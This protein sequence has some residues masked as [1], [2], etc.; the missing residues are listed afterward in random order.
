MGFASLNPSY[1]L[2]EIPDFA[3]CIRATRCGRCGS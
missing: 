3:S 2:H 1:A